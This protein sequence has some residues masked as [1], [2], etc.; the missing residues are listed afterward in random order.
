LENKTPGKSKP[1]N[2]VE[3]QRK[4]KG[5]ALQVPAGTTVA[6]LARAIWMATSDK[7]T[8]VPAAQRRETWKKEQPEYRKLARKVV[9]KLSRRGAKGKARETKPGA[10]TQK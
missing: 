10:D 5:N 1:A 2:V 7:N 3:K 6:K 8:S 9:A 4:G